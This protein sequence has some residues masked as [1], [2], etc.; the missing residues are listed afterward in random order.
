[1]TNLATEKQPIAI[2]ENE[3]KTPTFTVPTDR[4]TYIVTIHFSQTS[5]ETLEEK[6]KKMIWREAVGGVGG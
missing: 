5:K 1:M 6:V 4:G 2:E 3:D